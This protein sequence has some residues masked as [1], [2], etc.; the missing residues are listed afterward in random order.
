MSVIQSIAR[1]FCGC[2]PAVSLT[3]TGSF[4]GADAEAVAAHLE[5][6][7]SES[8]TA[9]GGRTE[10]YQPSPESSP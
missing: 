2:R 10:S 6:Y 7:L 4:I 8:L 9:S 5:R 1:R 3:I